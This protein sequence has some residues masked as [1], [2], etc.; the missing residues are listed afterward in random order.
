M[1]G[2]DLRALQR[3]RA[4]R[5]IHC[6]RAPAPGTRRAWRVSWSTPPWTRPHVARCDLLG[7]VQPAGMQ[8]RHHRRPTDTQDVLRRALEPLF[9]GAAVLLRGMEAPHQRARPNRFDVDGQPAL[10]RAPAIRNR[11][12]IP[13]SVHQAVGLE[14]LECIGDHRLSDPG[15]RRD[16]ADRRVEQCGLS[17]EREQDL[18]SAGARHSS[19]GAFLDGLSSSPGSTPQ[20]GG[21]VRGRRSRPHRDSSSPPPAAAWRQWG[22]RTGRTGS[23]ACPR[24]ALPA[25]SSARSRPGGDGGPT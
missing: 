5:A 6:D 9:K 15:F 10:K 4:N 17:E 2:V 23:A 24:L 3:Q 14:S 8:L 19:L 21:P 1:R 11:A 20:I 13:V 22:A 25:R 7:S 16:C 18:T 12:V